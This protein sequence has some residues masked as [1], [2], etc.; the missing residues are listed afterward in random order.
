MIHCCPSCHSEKIS[1]TEY[2]NALTCEDCG[3]IFPEHEVGIHPQGIST[4]SSADDIPF[5]FQ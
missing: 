4:Q 5:H 1:F 3:H 2:I